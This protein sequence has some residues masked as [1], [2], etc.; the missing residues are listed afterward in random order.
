M[1]KRLTT[2]LNTLPPALS[3]LA[4]GPEQTRRAV[5]SA[6]RRLI[7]IQVPAA[8]LIICA[9][10]TAKS[11]GLVAH[12]GY[13][14]YFAD[15]C[16]S[17]VFLW[18]PTMLALCLA[19]WRDSLHPSP[20]RSRLMTLAAGASI[21]ATVSGTVLVGAFAFGLCTLLRSH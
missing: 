8:L 2:E 17:T 4:S 3:W 21:I 7:L 18:P 15:L 12:K 14:S 1:L 16:A 11:W 19:A 10:A 5:I 20:L 13:A 9:I 6:K